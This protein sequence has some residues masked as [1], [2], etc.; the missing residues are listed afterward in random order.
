MILCTSPSWIIICLWEEWESH[1]TDPNPTLGAKFSLEKLNPTQPV[2]VL[3]RNKSLP[4]N[5]KKFLL[6]LLLSCSIIMAIADWYK[7]VF[8]SVNSKPSNFSVSSSLG[9]GEKMSYLLL[10]PGWGHRFCRGSPGT[11]PPGT[12]SNRYWQRPGCPQASM[13]VHCL[14]DA[15]WCCSHWCRWW[16]WVWASL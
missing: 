11:L 5:F 2:D 16:R 15:G 7:V 4:W 1:G 3:V 12:W 9:R 13:T 14:P 8:I 6:L 10:W